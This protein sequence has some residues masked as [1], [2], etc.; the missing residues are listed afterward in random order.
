MSPEDPWVLA[1]PKVAA[2]R[3]RTDRERDYLTQMRQQQAERE[4]R[5]RTNT[6]LARRAAKPYSLPIKPNE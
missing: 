4:D 2:R 6:A 5:Q 3:M 1:G